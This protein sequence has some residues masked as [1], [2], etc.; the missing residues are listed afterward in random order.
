MTS[1][2]SKELLSLQ[3]SRDQDFLLLKKPYR[4]NEL[5]NMLRRELR[6]DSASNPLRAWS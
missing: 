2:Y 6:T 4:I 1:G 5:A 3:Q